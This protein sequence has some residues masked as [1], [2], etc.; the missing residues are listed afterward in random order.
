MTIDSGWVKILKANCPS[1]FSH[2]IP[3]TPHTVFIDGQ[4]KLMKSDAITTWEL[5][6]KVQFEATIR[7]AFKTGASVVILGFDNYKHVPDAKAPT[8]RKRCNKIDYYEFGEL[9]TLPTI[10]P[11]SWAQAI[12]NRSFKAKVIKMICHNLER[13]AELND[14]TLIIDWLDT[15]IVL[16]AQLQLPR[17]CTNIENKRGE[18]DIKAFNYLELGSLCI[19]STDG[20]YIPIALLHAHENP[21]VLLRYTTTMPQDKKRKRGETSKALKY[22][23]V[24]INPLATFLQNDLKTFPRPFET[25]ALLVA[26]TGCDFTLNLPRL[27][28]AKLWANRRIWKKIEFADSV[29]CRQNLLCTILEMY[30]ILFKN[31]ITDKNKLNEKNRDAAQAYETL[32]KHITTLPSNVDWTFE[33]VCAH[34]KNTLWTVLYWQRLHD[35]PIP[36]GTNDQCASLYGFCLDPSGR[37]IFEAITK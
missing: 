20:D 32:K 11:S 37:T 2:A 22:E 17:A 26:A 9:D 24:N 35:Y 34:V 13:L 15:P 8:Q 3:F 30:L 5:F 6:Y 27:G 14:K 33:R 31:K 23:Y 4:I 19:F 36:T 21:I 1:A 29:D 16:G 28:P 12:R 10:I 18:C 25:F 7:N